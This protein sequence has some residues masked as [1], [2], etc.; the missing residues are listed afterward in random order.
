MIQG[1][2]QTC[3]KRQKQPNHLKKAILGNGK[4]VLLDAEEGRAHG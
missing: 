4:A 3:L 1:K 2:K